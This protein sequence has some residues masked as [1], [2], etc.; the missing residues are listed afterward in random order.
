M[1]FCV[2]MKESVCNEILFQKCVLVPFIS[3][4]FHFGSI[5]YISFDKINTYYQIDYNMYY[6][7]FDQNKSIIH[8]HVRTRIC[9]DEYR[10]EQINIRANN[11]TNGSQK[12]KQKKKIKH[13]SNKLFDLKAYNSYILIG[14]NNK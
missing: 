12:E 7:L 8:T 9:F 13:T 4:V 14:V 3:T 6:A 10:V 1:L 2:C 5:V 11:S